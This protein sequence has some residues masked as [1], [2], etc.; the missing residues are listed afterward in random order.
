MPLLS[1]MGRQ[2]D[3][4]G[5]EAGIQFAL[6]RILVDPE[7]LF[8]IERDPGQVS[9]RRGLSGSATS[10]WRRGCRSSCGAAFRTT[11]CSTSRCSGKLKRSGGARAAGPAHAADAPRRWRWSTTSAASGWSC[12]QLRAVTP[13]LGVVPGVRREPARGDAAG[14]RAVPREPA[15]GGSQRG[16]A[17]DGE[18]HVLNERWRGTTGFPTST[19][20]AS[21]ASRSTTTRAAGLLGQAQH[22]DRHVVRE[23]HVAG[24]A[25]QVAAREPPRRAAAAAAAECAARC[26]E[27]GRGRPAALGARAAGAAPQESGLRELPRADG[28]AGL[29][30]RELRRDRQV[31][32]DERRRTP[33]TGDRSMRRGCCPTARRSTGASSCATCWSQPQGP[34]RRQP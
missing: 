25:R 20:A 11:S 34:V 16:R 21:G 19:A 24:A 27:R 26:R 28:S 22:P 18:L 10:S 2:Q 14:D 31:A 5:F 23:P 32:D 9:P 33:E 30:A 3:S 13:D 1:T 4:D 7:F 15:A 12:G 17:A 6:E 8:R 29:R